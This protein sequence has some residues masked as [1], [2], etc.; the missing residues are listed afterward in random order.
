M[1]NKAVLKIARK[2]MQQNE[3]VLDLREGKLWYNSYLSDCNT[4]FVR[5]IAIKEKEI[6][7]KNSIAEF[8]KI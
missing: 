6:K 4:N 7:V 2:K 1:N 3:P 8:E 5:T